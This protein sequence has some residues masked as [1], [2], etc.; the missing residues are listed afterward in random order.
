MRCLWLAVV[1]FAC[2]EASADWV[3]ETGYMSCGMG[4][5]ICAGALL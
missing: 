4:N 5:G 1:V 3:A 2:R